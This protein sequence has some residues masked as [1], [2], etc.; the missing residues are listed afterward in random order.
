[1][2]G[3][4]VEIGLL[5]RFEISMDGDRFGAERFD[6]RA[7]L[8]LVQYLALS[9]GRRR[10][11]EQIQHALWPDAGA[12]LA[13]RRLYKATTLARKALGSPTTVVVD[14]DTIVLFPEADVRID[15]DEFEALSLDDP[16]AIERGLH[17]YRGELLTDQPYAEWALARR[18]ALSDRHLDLLR[19]AGAWAS[20]VE[21]DPT[22][23][24]A[25]VAMMRSDL[26]AGN[27]SAVLRRYELLA[28]T[29]SAELG[30]R[31]GAE[32]EE[33]RL[34][35]LAGDGG[36]QSGQPIE[37]KPVSADDSLIGR[38]HA[39]KSVARAVQAGRLVTVCGPGGVGKTHLARHVAHQLSEEFDGRVWLCELGNLA[40]SDDLADEFLD[41]VGGAR[42]TDTDS[43][44]SAA[45]LIANRRALV[46]VDNCEHLIASTRTMITRLLAVCPELHLL[47][48]SREALE[49]PTEI[50]IQ[51]EP[52]SRASAIELFEAEV[53]RR[54]GTVDPDD[55]AVD[56]VCERL[57]D[58]PLAIVL[59]AARARALGVGG[60]E[61]MLDE[62]LDSLRIEG[63]PASA[64]HSSLRAAIDWSY[65]LL[66][67][68]EQALLS[69]LG[70]FANRFTIDGVLA[71]AGDRDGRRDNEILDDFDRLVRRSLVAGP[72]TGP[73]G[74]TYR[75]LESV[76]L[77]AREKSRDH[78]AADAHLDYV[79][80]RVS[81]SGPLL[82]VDSDRAI[83]RFNF[84]W[85]DIRLA[86]LHAG[87][88]DDD[89]ALV[90][91]LGNV[92]PFALTLL[93]FEFLDWC[94]ASIGPDPE[95]LPTVMHARTAAAKAVL[96]AYR[97]QAQRSLALA[98]RASTVAPD[99]DVVLFAVGW[100]QGATGQGDLGRASF[101][102]LV[103]DPAGTAG[104]LR[105]G[106]LLA[107]AVVY[108]V[109]VDLKPLVAMAEAM[110]DQG[111]LYRINHL[112]IRGL[113]HLYH[114][115][116][117][118]A[119]ADLDR[120]IELAD[121]SQHRFNSTAIRDL[122]AYTHLH[123]TTEAQACWAVL[124]ALEWPAKRG[125]WPLAVN[126]LGLG[127]AVLSRGGD[128]EFATMVLAA[129]HQSELR[130]RSES[131]RNHL[132]AD[133]R[134]HPEF[135]AW[136][137]AGEAMDLRGAINLTTNLLE[138]KLAAGRAQSGRR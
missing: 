16:A 68:D 27:V 57:D 120:S 117:D 100:L 119:V 78:G 122:R 108:S 98:E 25:H 9:P 67:A 51:L 72:S 90:D 34:A 66:S 81:T 35:A 26:D 110:A 18:R 49:T 128:H 53:A 87:A 86:R 73:D 58:A 137:S 50:V 7:G 111:G 56:R 113:Y 47:A 54:G 17:L 6:R 138:A 61:R 106:A 41:S 42:H 65:D 20:V 93:R 5:G 11:R 23:E 3:G 105:S 97:G 52:L 88:K 96:S 131:N 60:I 102:R 130:H 8:H 24:P 77:F 76:R 114:G 74:S 55:P 116:V 15:C 92:A 135:D 80:D 133:L 91:L 101:E 123:F 136:W 62:R 109:H 94:E 70:A 134:K 12:D 59:A 19:A 39:V 40:N 29:L 46:V 31:P 43:F 112:A 124:D 63:E 104:S 64:H 132:L 115:S 71:V 28:A 84:D 1:M 36:G 95:E 37:G 4:L 125:V 38:Y 13:R 30:S 45:R 75:L 48:T 121:S 129:S 89:T 103:A 82:R 22:D 44:D 69:D 99:D 21:L 79:L 127:A 32:A 118:E 33:L 10:H 14:G 83:S 2:A 85:D 107:L 126:A